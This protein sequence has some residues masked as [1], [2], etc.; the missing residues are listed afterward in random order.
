MMRQI[1]R[2]EFQTEINDLYGKMS[3]VIGMGKV[4]QLFFENL[5]F[6]SLGFTPVIQ[7]YRVTGCV[8]TELSSAFR[9]SSLSLSLSTPP[10]LSLHCPKIMSWVNTVVSFHICVYTHMCTC[11][12]EHT[13]NIEFR[14]NI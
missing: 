8:S 11:I 3:S 12:Y 6:F 1:G 7:S 5:S 14:I 10:S 2:A 13:R 9:R 4:T